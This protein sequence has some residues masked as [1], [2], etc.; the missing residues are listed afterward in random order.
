MKTAHINRIN[1]LLRLHVTLNQFPLDPT[2]DIRLGRYTKNERGRDICSLSQ[3][4]MS[5]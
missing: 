1:G 2:A 5:L 3:P 4:M